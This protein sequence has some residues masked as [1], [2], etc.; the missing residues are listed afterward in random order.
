MMTHVYLSGPIDFRSEESL[1]SCTAW[2]TF[3]EDKLSS[4][5]IHSI[6]PM[7]GGAH[8]KPTQTFSDMNDGKALVTRDLRDMERCDVMLVVFPSDVSKRGIGTLMEMMYAS[9]AGKPIILVD[10]AGQV[11]NH[12]WVQFAVT[13][14]YPCV[15][16]AI[17]RIGGYWH[18]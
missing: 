17:E 14:N 1:E 5:G 13:E 10:P 8:L 7:R 15:P 16:T 11:A 2:R 9:L 6:N 3:A 12:P 4:M 18:D